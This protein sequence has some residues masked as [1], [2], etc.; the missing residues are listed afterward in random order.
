[1][2]FTY[3]KIVYYHTPKTRK[4]YFSQVESK[5]R[6]KWKDVEKNKTTRRARGERRR[7][8]VLNHLRQGRGYF[9]RRQ[10]IISNYFEVQTVSE[11]LPT[12]SGLS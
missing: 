10:T 6:T 1:M 9:H 8:A 3:L 5:K 2:E 11:A 12:T 7:G 4:N